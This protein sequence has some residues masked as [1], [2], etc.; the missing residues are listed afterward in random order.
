MATRSLGALTLDLLLKTGGFKAGMDLAAR[1][2]ARGSQEIA[3]S[4]K[5]AAKL[6]EA[7]R[8]PLEVLMANLKE[9]KRLA[10]DPAIPA[11]YRIT[12]QTLERATQEEL[13][14]YKQRS[15]A[16]QA[17]AALQAE[18]KGIIESQRSA[19]ENLIRTEQRLLGMMKLKLLTQE[20]VNAAMAQARAATPDARAGAAIRAQQATPLQIRDTSIAEA[21]RLA[22]AG[23]LSLKEMNAEIARARQEYHQTSAAGKEFIAMEERMKSALAA[24]ETALERHTREMRDYDTALKRNIID[25]AEFNRLAASSRATLA[26]ST[27][28]V[29]RATSSLATFGATLLRQAT[30]FVTV[31]AAYAGARKVLTIAND[32][33]LLENRLRLVTKSGGELVRVQK[34]LFD[35]AQRTRQEY[36]GVVNLY[37]KLALTQ[38]DL[39]ASQQDL[40]KF[41]E[42]VGNAL[43]ISGTSAQTARGAL[44]QLAQGLASG[45]FRAEE[46]NAVLEGSPE[47]I[48]IVARNIERFHGSVGALRLAVQQSKLGSQ[49][50]FQAFL[51]GSDELK[52]RV[53]ALPLTISQAF[54]QLQNSFNKA[55]AQGGDVSPFVDAIK[56]LKTAVEDPEVQRGIATLT[57]LIVQL[58]TGVARLAA[59]FGTEFGKI[60]DALNYIGRLGGAAKDA[61]KSVD[62][63][64]SSLGYLP[65]ALAGALGP[66]G[67]IVDALSLFNVET[68]K[69]IEQTRKFA[70]GNALRLLVGGPLSIFSHA[71]TEY[72]A[73]LEQIK[74]VSEHVDTVLNRSGP[75]NPRGFPKPAE[76]KDGG[77]GDAKEIERAQKAILDLLASLRQQREVLG[78]TQEATMRYR[79]EFGDLADEFKKAG[80]A[81][82]KYRDELIRTARQLDQF[83]AGEELKKANE[84]LAQQVVEI[85]ATRIEQTQG[86][87][88]AEKYREAHG[89]LAKTIHT[90]RGELDAYGKLLSTPQDATQGVKDTEQAIRAQGAAVQGVAQE[91]ETLEL[92][93]S[94]SKDA[95]VSFGTATAQTLDKVTGDVA[96]MRDQVAKTLGDRQQLIIQATIVGLPQA[97]EDLQK[98]VLEATGDT[99]GAARLEIEQEFRAQ[100]ANLQ[101]ILDQGDA[102]QIPAELHIT[103]EQARAQAQAALARIAQLEQAKLR[104]A[105]IEPINQRIEDIN[106]QYGRAEQRLQTRIEAGLIS[107]IRARKELVRIHQQQAAALEVEAAKLRAIPD[108]T[109]EQIRNLKELEATIE[110]LKQTTDEFKKVFADAF[111]TGAAD[112]LFDLAKGVSSLEDATV[113]FLGGIQDEILHWATQELAAAMRDAWFGGIK[114]AGKGLFTGAGGGFAGLK[115]MFRGLFG[116]PQAGAGLE[117]IK[118]TAQRLPEA[119]A[120]A[121]AASGL[122]STTA[123]FLPATQTLQSAAEVLLEAAQALQQCECVSMTG[124]GVPAGAGLEPIT[125]TAARL[126]ER[127]PGAPVA[128]A[129]MFP[130]S[131]VSTGE[132]RGRLAKDVAGIVAGLID[133]KLA[134]MLKLMDLVRV[135]RGGALP[136][137]TIPVDT[138]A[139]GAAP[140]GA[141]A[142]RV[143]ATAGV[144]A[145]ALTAAATAMATASTALGTAMTSS[146]TAL[147]TAATALQ[148]AAQA[149]ATSGGATGAGSGVAGLFG[150]GGGAGE[151][152][153]LLITAKYIRGGGLVAR[154]PSGPIIVRPK[155][156]AEGGLGKPPYGLIRGPGTGTS[157][158][159]PARVS[160]HEY[161]MPAHVVERPGVYD[162]LER[163]RKGQFQSA[164]ELRQFLHHEPVAPRHFAAGGLVRH[165]NA[166]LASVN[167]R[168]SDWVSGWQPPAAPQG[169]SITQHV[170][171]Q[172]HFEQPQSRQT[173]LQVAAAAARGLKRADQR[174]N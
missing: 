56:D 69:A 84:A 102:L 85:Q 113:K 131:L 118:V 86:T 64:V 43:T 46:F 172:F 22:H 121:T 15:A 30:G 28:N 144:D 29:G 23:E 58:A 109:R 152:E 87:L 149:L 150:L 26:Q 66:L 51:K 65:E 158:S 145:G 9:Y 73:Q 171:N 103:V 10:T 18:A 40:V 32:Y 108:K 137:G 112:A 24:T 81:F 167:A 142:A 11:A 163:M 122:Q 153:P 77:L 123:Q 80:P 31:Y 19:T 105:Q 20:Q 59:E 170:T 27:Q 156:F 36:A 168:P 97:L 1:E 82:A 5:K 143:P 44:T 135:M 148:Q 3:A 159:I 49:E 67:L 8:T 33:A 6:T 154:A 92:V 138:L 25:Q 12:Q 164:R 132:E 169:T 114:D 61:A 124:A 104:E 101:A 79:I 119:T 125:V 139:G 94:K 106:S 165:T 71:A 76:V 39:G 68:G 34:E 72:L 174:N 146:A 96:H 107:E 90:A 88:A 45:V 70:T 2:A 111:E 57:G 147:Q 37:S 41:T 38:K 17:W 134:L 52:A 173:Q 21:V 95:V 98:A 78:E 116:L 7:M 99:L 166:G 60:V 14:L 128:G 93:W 42:A 160:N 47:I 162:L 117:E 157:D 53:A 133:P 136:P 126:P 91:V 4:M 155:F 75:R 50:F 110:D 120:L 62:T 140:L 161:F 13:R 100:K 54:Q 141:V 16:H 129:G 48:R 83:K 74:R 89:E 151:L 127:G 55:I 35:V 63:F 115:D 130:S